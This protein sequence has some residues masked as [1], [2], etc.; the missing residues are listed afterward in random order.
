MTTVVTLV[1]C[2]LGTY[3]V[4]REKVNPKFL[5]KKSAPTPSSSEG[6]EPPVESPMVQ[7]EDDTPCTLCKQGPPKPHPLVQQ[8]VISQD[9]ADVLVM[10]KY[11][12]TEKKVS[13]RRIPGARLMT[14]KLYLSL[15][16][17]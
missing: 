4:D 5:V 14:S 7:P 16:L 17:N 1:Y 3:P 6:T 9:L 12:K 13:N 15:P 10:P 8:G 2:Y 11:S